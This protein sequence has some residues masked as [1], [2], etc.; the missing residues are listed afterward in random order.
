MR[1]TNDYVPTD[2]NVNARPSFQEFGSVTCDPKSEPAKTPYQNVRV[3]PQPNVELVVGTPVASIP[4]SEA[5][6]AVS[7]GKPR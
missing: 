1:N 5:S 3:T 4:K 6:P 2:R 7:P